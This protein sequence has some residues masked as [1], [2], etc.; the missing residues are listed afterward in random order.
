MPLFVH[1]T[2]L[3][4]TRLV[5]RTGLRC[6][7][8]AGERP[9]GVFAVPVGPNFFVTH[10]W[11]RELR[12]VGGR[13]VVGV[14]FRV[15]D[16]EAVWVGRYNEP[17]RWVT[18]AEASALFRTTDHRLGWEAVVPRSI[19]PAEVHRVRPVSPVVG[20]RFSPTAKGRPPFCGCSYCTRGEYNARRLR[21]RLKAWG[22]G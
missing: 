17:H 15:G 10:Q 18:A 14:Y 7:P 20:W 22:Q 16:D 13:S 2:R 4:N 6:S 12:R 3:T 19:R 5:R 8:G 1:I 11:V 9:A 21:V